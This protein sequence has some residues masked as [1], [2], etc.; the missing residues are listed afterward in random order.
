MKKLISLF[1]VIFISIFSA[2]SQDFLDLEKNKNCDFRAV[3]PDNDWRK[4]G[5]LVQ[6]EA[7]NYKNSFFKAI[8][9]PGKKILVKNTSKNHD[10]K[11]FFKKIVEKEKEEIFYSKKDKKILL[12]KHE[13]TFEI[14]KCYLSIL[15][16]SSIVL[17]LLS[18][19]FKKKNKIITIIFMML[20]LFSIFFFS[21]KIIINFNGISAIFPLLIFIFGIFSFLN[22]Q[23]FAK[24]SYSSIFYRKYLINICVSLIW[25]MAI[26]L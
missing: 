5:I 20:S 16:L 22:L 10:L 18:L 9:S 6:K 7:K 13:K 26:F 1:L 8:E 11:L 21:I 25:A 23:Y 15:I 3:S 17:I 4:T 19:L 14:E 24:N 12:V 2:N